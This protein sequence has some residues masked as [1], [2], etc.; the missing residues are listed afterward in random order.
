MITARRAAVICMDGGRRHIPTRARPSWM[1]CA[2]ARQEA[3]LCAPASVSYRPAYTTKTQRKPRCSR[4]VDLRLHP[5]SVG[6]TGSTPAREPRRRRWRWP[7]VPGPT[8]RPPAEGLP[9][10]DKPALC[11]TRQHP[12]PLVEPFSATSEGMPSPPQSQIDTER[13]HA[14]SVSAVD[15]VQRGDLTEV[16]AL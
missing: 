10:N 15:N 13:V 5:R 6:G 7:A 1:I 12:R 8:R 4:P 14:C 3:D 2:L 9:H 16:I 11:S